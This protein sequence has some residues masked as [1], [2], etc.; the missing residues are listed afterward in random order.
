MSYIS[1]VGDESLAVDRALERL[2]ELAGQATEGMSLLV[3]KQ[4]QL[5]YNI[6]QR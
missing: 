4:A 1:R 6:L 3:P 2:C 5:S